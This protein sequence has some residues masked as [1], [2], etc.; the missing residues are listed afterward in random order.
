MS[1][2]SEEII[3]LQLRIIELEKQQQIENETLNKNS[4]T[5]NFTIITDLLTEKK[6]SIKN[7]RYSKNVPLARYYDEELVT[8]LEAIY[9][10]LQILD[11]RIR[12]IENNK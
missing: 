7:N 1:F 5:H 8:H 6:T 11:S 10:I 12:K 2:V 9:N 3:K 4:I